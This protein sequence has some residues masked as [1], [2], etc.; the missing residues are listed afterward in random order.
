VASLFFPTRVTALIPIW[1]IQR[2]LGLINLTWALVLPYTALTVALGAFIMKGVFEGISGELVDAARIDGAGPLRI[3]GS[4]LLPLV[5]NG[6]LVV[7]MVAYV[8]AWG[9]FLLA[10]TLINDQEARTLV[11]ALAGNMVGLGARS[12]PEVA[13]VY[14]LAVAPSV[15]FFALTQRWFVRGLLEGALKH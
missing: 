12:E 15:A 3:L 13:V 7:A 11:P 1:E 10:A 5:A 14:V 2:S 8:G 6:V 4:V 9:E